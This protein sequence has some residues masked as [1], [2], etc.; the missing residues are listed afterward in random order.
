MELYIFNR[1]LEFQGIVDTFT[2]FRWIRRYHKP[3]EF[4]LHCRLTQENLNLLQRENIIWKKDN[5]E[6]GYI[7]YRELKLNENGQEELIIKGKF[8]TSYLSRR[9]IW[10]QEILQTTA[11]QA[12]RDLVNRHCIT[13]SV[14]R[15]I[16]NLI[17]SDLKSYAESINYQTSYN[18]LLDELEN[19]SNISNLGYKVNFDAVN[20][21]LIFEVYKG[22]DR[23]VNQTTNAQAIF[24]RDFEN[25]LEQQYIDSIHNFRNVALV[26]GIGEGIARVMVT[27][28]QAT[29][30]DR[31]EIF[32]DARDVSD[33][34]QVGE[35]EMQLTE[36]EYLQMLQ[37]RGNAKLAEQTEL[38]TFDSKINMQGNLRYKQ[39]FD[40]GDIVTVIDKKWNIRVNTRITEIEE[41]YEANKEEINVVF[42]N[43]IPTLIDKIKQIVR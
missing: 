5:T 4:E 43:N 7:E 23:S 28:G 36:Q 14:D 13:T 37:E 35:T 20:K 6:A 2:S 9:I 12:M 25:I 3:G 38:K 19:I 41:I 32:V 21:Q 26:G 17:L 39:D 40:L 27:V 34:K 8:L 31:L 1:N 29:G 22:L 24:S 10:G 15:V 30:L 33:K 42:G 18:N 16:P 11:E